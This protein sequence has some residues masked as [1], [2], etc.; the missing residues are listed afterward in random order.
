MSPH[1][2]LPFCLQGGGARSVLLSRT[3]GERTRENSSH[4][5][6]RTVHR[7]KKIKKFTAIRSAI[8]EHICAINPIGELKRRMST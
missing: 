3:G 2:P 7:E 5:P 4:E 1:H 6:Y 8:S